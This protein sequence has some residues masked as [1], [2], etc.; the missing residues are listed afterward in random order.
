MR[1]AHNSESWHPWIKKLQDAAKTVWYIGD[2]SFPSN[3]ARNLGDNYVAVTGDGLLSVL[4][5]I[6][7][8][9]GDGKLRYHN[10]YW[11]NAKGAEGYPSMMGRTFHQ[12]GVRHDQEMTFPEAIKL[13]LDHNEQENK[14]WNH[15]KK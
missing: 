4:W 3:T 10:L 1:N 15:F 6:L 7:S 5:E 11:D 9:E 12:L 2:V 13:V 8:V 14:K